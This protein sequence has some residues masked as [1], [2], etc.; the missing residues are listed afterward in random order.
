[1]HKTCWASG[2][3]APN[4]RPFFCVPKNKGQLTTLMTILTEMFSVFFFLRLDMICI[5]AP[6]CIRHWPCFSWTN[7]TC[8]FGKFQEHL[9][10]DLLIYNR[11]LLF[12]YFFKLFLKTDRLSSVIC[13]SVCKFFTFSSSSSEPP[14]HIQPNLAQSLAAPVASNNILWYQSHNRI[15]HTVINT[16]D[17]LKKRGSTD[18][19]YYLFIPFEFMASVNMMVFT[20]TA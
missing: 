20:Q 19:G 10:F 6:T 14:S 2:A 13:P 18:N 5:C 4:P 12:T 17:T 1:M 8:T 16:L 11:L 9:H 3:W 7:Y 15:S